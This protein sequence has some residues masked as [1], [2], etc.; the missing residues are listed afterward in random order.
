MDE[1]KI[2]VKY[3]DLLNHIKSTRNPSDPVCVS[4]KE[5]SSTHIS[6]LPMEVILY[7]FRWVVSSELDLRHVII[8]TVACFFLDFSQ[9]HIASN[10]FNRHC[11]NEKYHYIYIINT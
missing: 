3:D 5:Q 10:S 8:F 9:L 11:E 7:I 4:F 1:D 2:L 6:Q